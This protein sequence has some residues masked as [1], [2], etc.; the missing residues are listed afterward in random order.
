MIQNTIY[1]QTSLP[2]S[3]LLRRKIREEVD[4]VLLGSEFKNKLPTRQ[5]IK[6]SSKRTVFGSFADWYFHINPSYTNMPVLVLD[7]LGDI[8][9]K[10]KN[11]ITEVKTMNRSNIEKLKN[12]KWLAIKGIG[13]KFAEQLGLHNI[14]FEEWVRGK[15][16]EVYHNSM[17]EALYGK[18]ASYSFTVVD[19]SNNP[20]L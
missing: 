13:P 12:T 14:T 6:I 20:Y 7:D 5:S 15:K 11:H 9:A 4:E 18:N 16:I 19:L 1:I 10:I 3:K 17:K 2:I 8:R